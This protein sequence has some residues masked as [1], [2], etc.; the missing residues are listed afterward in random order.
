LIGG[1]IIGKVGVV[2]GGVGLNGGITPTPRIGPGGIGLA[3][4]ELTAG[5][6]FGGVFATRAEPGIG[7]AFGGLG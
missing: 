4:A 2:R 1:T 7:S 6:G 3:G 5:S